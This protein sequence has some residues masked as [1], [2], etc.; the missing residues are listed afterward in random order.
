MVINMENR[1]KITLKTIIRNLDAI[2]TGTTL[3]LAT[4]IVNLNVI[5]RK[6]FNSPLIWGEEFATGLFVWTVFIGSAYALRKRLHLG[7]DILV[8]AFPK[9]IQ[10]IITVIMDILVM[11]VLI[12]LTYVSILYVANTWDKMSNVMRLPSWYTSIAVPIGFGLSMI[13]AIRFVIIDM[14]SVFS[15]RKGEKANANIN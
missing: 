9:K 12:M 14:S 13:Y 4:I 3:S 7:V 1:S 5:M 2:I 11:L 10:G 15:K 8:K 6:V